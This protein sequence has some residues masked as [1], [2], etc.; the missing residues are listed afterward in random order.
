MSKMHIGSNLD[1]FLQDEGAFDEAHA[2]AIKEVVVWQLTE[3]MAKQSLSKA[4][5]A[6]MLKKL[7]AGRP[8]ARS[9]PRRN[10][11]D[12]AARRGPGRPQSADRAG[13]RDACA[14]GHCGGA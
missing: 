2:L 6:V 1:D 9:D 13:A 14:A 10:R 3:V 12:P 7:F 8:A 4:R 11:L 5:L